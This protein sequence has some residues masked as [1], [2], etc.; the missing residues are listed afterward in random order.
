MSDFQLETAFLNQK[1]TRIKVGETY[2]YFVNAHRAKK[3]A[4]GN[5]IGYVTFSLVLWEREFKALA[6]SCS[7]GDGIQMR[8]HSETLYMPETGKSNTWHYPRHVY[9]K[10]VKMSGMLPVMDDNGNV[11][12]EYKYVAPF[13]RLIYSKSKEKSCTPKRFQITDKVMSV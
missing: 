1:V 3:D 11:E 7:V 10:T 13:F 5:L 12:Y 2:K 4:D 6:A 9:S 8:V